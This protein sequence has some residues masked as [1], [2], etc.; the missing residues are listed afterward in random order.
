MLNDTQDKLPGTQLQA[1]I[2]EIKE[3]S[4]LS[5]DEFNLPASKVLLRT[6]Y[7]QLAGYQNE[8]KKVKS[9]T[10]RIVKNN[11]LLTLELLID[12]LLNTEEAAQ[13]LAYHA[14][15]N[16]VEKYNTSIGTGLITDSIP[17]LEEILVFWRGLSGKY[18]DL[19]V[20]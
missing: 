5:A 10:V 20:F 3:V 6:L 8:A 14:T 7:R 16:H 19:S 1:I 12:C 13:N 18:G 11:D 4:Q 9:T 2:P 15:R 17:A